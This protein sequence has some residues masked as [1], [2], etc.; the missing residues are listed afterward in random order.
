MLARA[1]QVIEWWEGASSSRCSA[2]R[3]PPSGEASRQTS[4][5]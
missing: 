2:A 3:R 1:D 4:R 5:H